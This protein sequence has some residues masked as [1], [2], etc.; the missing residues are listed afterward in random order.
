MQIEETFRDIKNSRWGFSLD[1]ARVNST[2]LYEN[3]L[4]IG[5][6]AHFAVWLTG[7][8]AE[9]KRLH[10]RFQANTVKTHKVLS[11]FYLG[12]RVLDKGIVFRQHEYIEAM[13]ALKQHIQVQSWA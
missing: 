13:R 11:T 12:C 2:H 4:L 9:M 6:L 7:I 5:S 1:E 10:Q 8:I 3:L